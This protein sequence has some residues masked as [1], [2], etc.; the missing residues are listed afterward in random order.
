[1]LFVAKFLNPYCGGIFAWKG[2]GCRFDLDFGACSGQTAFHNILEKQP[3]NLLDVIVEHARATSKGA[4]PH[5][6]PK[7]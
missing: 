2:A 3:F 7:A 1:M 4:L 5:Y 6:F